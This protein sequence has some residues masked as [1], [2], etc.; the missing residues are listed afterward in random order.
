MNLLDRLIA[1]VAPRLGVARAR[2]RATLGAYE[3][4]DRGRKN[5]DWRTRAAASADL[6]Y[7]ADAETINARARDLYRNSWLARSAVR[8]RRRNTVRTGIIPVSTAT[9][10]DGTVNESLRA[11]IDAAFMTWASDRQRCDVEQKS[12]FWKFQRR[13]VSEQML[14]GEHFVVW[15]YTPAHG[16]RLQSFEPEQLNL[17][18]QS[19][20]EEGVTREVR[21]GVEVDEFG[22]PVAYHFWRRPPNDHLGRLL[23]QPLRLPASRVL[24][25]F[26]AE[27]ALQTRGVSEF[28]PVVSKIR[29]LHRFDDAEMWATLMQACIGAVI[30]TEAG[31]AAVSPGLPP[32]AGADTTTASGL[33]L[34]DF[35]PGMVAKLAPGEKV[36]MLAPPRPGNT[37]Q[38]YVDANTRA[39]AAG[40]GHSW[41]DVIRQS[42]GNYSAARQDLLTDQAEADIYQD[43]LIELVIQ[44]IYRLFVGFWVLEGH[45]EP[46]GLT[47]EA[48]ASDPSRYTEAEYQTPVKPWIDPQAE[49]NGFEKLLQ[50]RLTTR[51]EII[52]SQGGRWGRKLREMSAERREAAAEGITFPE[53]A[54]TEALRRQ[55]CDCE[56]E[57]AQ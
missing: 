50:L 43:D 24:H 23:L 11:A 32:A 7:I 44:P 56:L 22:A 2:A 4:A 52:A 18:V 46:Y 12:T 35:V 57:A 17:N 36:E 28:A 19:H 14:V 21:G 40:L 55:S 29:N 42:Q 26:D 34:F 8:A 49:A 45:G 27:R 1:Y 54:A 13:C 31:A 53:D 48:F 47:A 25:F 9:N 38:P 15:S 3:A 41:G 16:F 10:A 33:P 51:K 5:A 6:D 30:T 20:T 37:Y 39:I